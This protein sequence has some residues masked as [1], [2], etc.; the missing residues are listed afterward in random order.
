VLK[1]DLLV[2]FGFLDDFFQQSHNSSIS[3]VD[4]ADIMALSVFQS[5]LL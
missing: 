1:A 2:F 5:L 4:K 3:S